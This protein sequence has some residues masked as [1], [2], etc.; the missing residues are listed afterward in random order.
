MRCGMRVIL[1]SPQSR[2][3]EPQALLRSRALG[4]FQFARVMK[5]EGKHTP[6][7]VQLSYEQSF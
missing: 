3:L 2:F 4:I 6:V 1:A 5:I 7:T